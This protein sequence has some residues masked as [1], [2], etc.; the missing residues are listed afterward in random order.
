M[1]VQWISAQASSGEGERLNCPLTSALWLKST[2]KDERTKYSGDPTTSA[3]RV[4]RRA[5]SRMSVF[6]C[7]CVCVFVSTPCLSVQ[8]TLRKGLGGD[9]LSRFGLASGA[10]FNEEPRFITLIWRS[11]HFPHFSV[12]FQI[13]SPV[14]DSW[15]QWPVLVCVGFTFN[16]LQTFPVPIFFFFFLRECMRAISI[17]ILQYI[18][19]VN[20]FYLHMHDIT[21][22]I[23]LTHTHTQTGC[24]I[25]VF[26]GQFGGLAV[27]GDDK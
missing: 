25:K 15:T 7:V 5:V 22:N 17:I 3:C 21:I 16:T 27:R 26:R 20:L 1:P 19:P 9:E 13:S 18:L 10:D 4:R 11:W 24:V 14:P 12:L 23:P 8:L 2:L 6:T